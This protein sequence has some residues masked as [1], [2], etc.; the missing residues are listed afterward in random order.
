MRKKK[1]PAKKK[2][3]S[4]AA[5]KTAPAKGN[6][7]PIPTNGPQF[8]QPVATPDPSVFSVLHGSDNAA[9]K[10]LDAEKSKLL[11]RPF[12]IAKTVEPALTLADAL[13]DPAGASVT[14]D[15]QR[16]G[17]IVF[18]SMVTGNARQWGRSRSPDNYRE[19][20]TRASFDMVKTLLETP[21][22]QA[23]IDVKEPASVPPPAPAPTVVP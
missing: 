5:P 7:K 17:Q 2:S 11:P 20:L 12:P 23:A 1:A 15:L 22:F 3:A 9:Y 8:A 6:T 16:A 14:A 10:I 13:G 21:A 19:V 4:R 18:A